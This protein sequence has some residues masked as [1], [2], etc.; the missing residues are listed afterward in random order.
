MPADFRV[1]ITNAPGKGAYPIASFTWLL[2]P[3]QWQ[4]QGKKQ[5]RVDF[6]NWMLSNGQGMVKDLSYAPLPNEV[7]SKVKD[8]L[9]QIK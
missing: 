3:V 2:I 5:A 9:K 8:T 6:L 4:D 7:V 1:S